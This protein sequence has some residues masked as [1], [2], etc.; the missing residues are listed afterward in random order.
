LA[1]NGTD[2]EEANKR[3]ALAVNTIA[4]CAPQ[5]VINALISFHDDVKF[6]NKSK[7]VERYGQLLKELL[8]VI[9]KDIKLSNKDNA[10]TFNFHLIGSVSK[11]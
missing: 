10:S 4:L 5:S 6:S 8:I 2:K 9:R 3:L 7:S 11:G 1:V